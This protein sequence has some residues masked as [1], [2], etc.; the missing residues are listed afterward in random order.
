MYNCKQKRDPGLACSRINKLIE[1][2]WSK[3]LPT[4]NLHPRHEREHE[5]NG[6]SELPKYIPGFRRTCSSSF[7][8]FMARE[9]A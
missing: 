6:Y 9:A 4:S 7:F 5:V 2:L 3:G 8:E 1:I